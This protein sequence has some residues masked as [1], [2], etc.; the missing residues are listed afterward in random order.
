M[1]HDKQRIHWVGNDR[2]GNYHRIPLDYAGN[3]LVDPG[4]TVSMLISAI[5]RIQH[6]PENCSCLGWQVG[7]AYWR[8]AQVLRWLDEQMDEN[9]GE[10]AEEVRVIHGRLAPYRTPTQPK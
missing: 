10:H 9:E 1:K 4:G 5:Y 8:T 6:Q 7:G 3:P 2:T